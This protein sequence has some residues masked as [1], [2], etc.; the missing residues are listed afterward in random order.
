MDIYL[1]FKTFVFYILRLITIYF[2]RTLNFPILVGGTPQLGLNT[3]QHAQRQTFPEKKIPLKKKVP[4]SYVHLSNMWAM[5]DSNTPPP[6][7]ARVFYLATEQACRYCCRTHVYICPM[8]TFEVP[9]FL[10]GLLFYHQVR[11]C[12]RISFRSILFRIFPLWHHKQCVPTPEVCCLDSS[13][14]QSTLPRVM[15]QEGIFWKLTHSHIPA[16]K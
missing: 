4:I 11:A 8:S 7:H 5:G 3:H 6:P 10:K 1:Y 12:S 14:D 13:A 15:S 16:V 9:L 2:F